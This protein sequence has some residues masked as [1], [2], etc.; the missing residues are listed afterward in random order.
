MSVTVEGNV[1]IYVEEPEPVTVKVAADT[2]PLAAGSV[3][4]LVL[5]R[6]PA[7]ANTTVPPVAVCTARLPKLMSVFFEILI[8]VITVALAVA[9]AVD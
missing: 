7:G 9:V 6:V 5:V 3:T 8:G 1:I 4:P 2:E